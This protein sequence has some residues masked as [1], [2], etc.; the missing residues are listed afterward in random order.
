MLVM[1]AVMVMERM[2]LVLLLLREVM[3]LWDFGFE[4]I[5]QSRLLVLCTTVEAILICAIAV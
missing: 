2:R 5:Y 4:S 3:A 1:I